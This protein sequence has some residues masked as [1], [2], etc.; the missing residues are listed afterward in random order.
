MSYAG[1]SARTGSSKRG[2]S[3]GARATPADAGTAAAWRRGTSALATTSSASPRRGDREVPLA[4]T[5]RR[6]ARPRLDDEGLAWGEIALFATGALVGL[7]VGVGATLL[8]A[9]RSGA[10]TRREL[11]HRGRKLGD[12]TVD[13]WDDL[14]Y[15]LRRATRRGRNA[16][17]DRFAARR[18]RRAR[19]RD[20]ERELE[21]ERERERERDTLGV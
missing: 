20:L 11:A 13:A 6:G 2:A 7:T 21:L 4:G 17:G 3:R 9:P 8:F 5:A 14:R 12:R 18:E 1:K 16:L 15:E 19:H 10:E